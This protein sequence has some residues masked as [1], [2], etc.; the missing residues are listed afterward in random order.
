MK[1]KKTNK[2]AKKCPVCPS[3][4]FLYF[5]VGLLIIII[6]GGVVYLKN[7]NKITADIINTERQSTRTEV[8]K[9]VEDAALLVAQNPSKAYTEFR[10]PGGM[11]WKSDRYVFVYDMTGKT[12]VL[13][14]EQNLEGTNRIN[15]KDSNGV[16]YVKQMTE[17]LKNQNSG[18][19]SYSYPKPGKTTNS[20]KTSYFTKAKIGNSYVIVGSG[21]YLN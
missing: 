12:L 18:W 14:P 4:D 9:F 17:I 1:S 10:K 5:V 16:F 2:S 11:W 19:I 7:L 6:L 15:V 3:N 8:V 20:L 21:F 13:P